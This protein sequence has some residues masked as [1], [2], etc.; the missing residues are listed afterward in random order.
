V[1]GDPAPVPLDAVEDRE[2]LDRLHAE[3]RLLLHLAHEGLLQRL[4]ELHGAAGDGPPPVEGLLST[5]DE[6]DPPVPHDH[7]ADPDDG[8]PRAHGAGCGSFTGW[9]GSSR[10][11][12]TEAAHA[13][14]PDTAYRLERASSASA[15]D[16]SRKRS[17]IPRT[18]M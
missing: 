16:T 7:A 1:I 18:L 12:R 13:S 5:S 15:C 8:R 4:P 6:E 3:A 9:G 11:R 17:A 10:R 14:G 2:D